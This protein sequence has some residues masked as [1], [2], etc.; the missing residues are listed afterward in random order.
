SAGGH[1]ALITG[2]LNSANG[3]DDGCERPADKWAASG[4]PPNVRVAAI[5]NFFG[6]TD[7]PEFLQPPAKTHALRWFADVPN[8]MELAKR[9]SPVT[10]AR[11]DPPPIITVQGDKDPYVPYEQA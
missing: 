9:L 4:G 10:Y 11:K 8:R 2:M 5:V 3:F 6:I 7:V 1:L